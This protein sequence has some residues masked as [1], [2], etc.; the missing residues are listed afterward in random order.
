MVLADAPSA[1]TAFTP[2]AERLAAVLRAA[3]EYSIVGTDPAGVITVFNEGAERMLGYLAEEVVGVAT[4]LVF[5]DPSEIAA[6]ATEAGIAPGFDVFVLAARRGDAETREWTY[7]RKDATRLTVSLTVTAMQSEDGT[8]TGFIGIARDVTE[9]RRAEM[10]RARIEAERE[11]L[12]TRERMAHAAAERAAEWME[13][14]QRV[15]AALSAAETPEQVFDTA[16][17]EGQAALGAVVGHVAVLVE[18]GQELELVSVRG[19]APTWAQRGWRF[20]LAA[21]T[22][23]ADAVRRARPIF[24]AARGGE[25]SPVDGAGAP[26]L[27]AGAQAWCAAPLQVGQQALG[28]LVFAFAVARGFVEEDRQFL[29]AL[30]QQCAHALERALTR[31]ETERLKDEFFG[32]VS[33]DLRTP[34]AAIK[35]SVG[36]VLANEPPGFPEALHRMVANIDLAA[37]RLSRLVGDLLELTRAQAGRITLQRQS[38]DLRGLVQRAARAIEPL[39]QQRGQRLELLLPVRAVRL[40]VD[41][42]RLERVV[43][44]LLSN[45]QKFGAPNGTIRVGLERRRGE[46]RLTVSDD[47]PG[48]P[49]ADQRRVFERFY[50]MDAEV[51]RQTQGSGLGLAIAQALVALHGGR[52]WVESAPGAGATFVVALPALRLQRARASGD[53]A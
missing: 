16:L 13:R 5:H 33:H 46:V 19:S 31:A 35:A 44:N 50:R 17:E 30:T 34:V 37:D 22:P 53:A 27:L 39:A 47:G 14:L 49:E 11:Q 43:V 7:I 48:I 2:A 23:A 21:Q 42:E 26:A 32:N 36:V 45:A 24:V 41:V 10:E 51:R 12:L 18:G 38:C 6:R 52:I 28:A 8:L 9:Q 15:T 40:A 4:P 25:S 29:L 1:A 20:P 3:T